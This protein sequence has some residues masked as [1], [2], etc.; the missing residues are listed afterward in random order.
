MPS[1]LS[2][3]QL[4][5]KIASNFLEK[6]GYQIIE[7]NY[8][9]RRWGEIDLIA[10]DGD[11][12]AFVEVKTRIGDQ[13]LEPFEAVDNHK[14][15]TLKKSAYQFLSRNHQKRLPEAYRIDVV[16]VHFNSEEG[17]PKIELFKNVGGF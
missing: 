1:T 6:N 17:Q 8:R 7:K 15:R 12:L 5:E 2:L 4:G 10:I 16:S 13:M 14:L 3:G 9:A 11:T